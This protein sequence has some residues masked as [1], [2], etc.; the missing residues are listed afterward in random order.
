MA[1]YP[2]CRISLAKVMTQSKDHA[3][4]PDQ[5]SR[6]PRGGPARL[7]LAS[8]APH[9]R[10]K[11]SRAE[12]HAARR[13]WFALPPR[14]DGPGRARRAR[15]GT[16]ALDDPRDRGAGGAEPAAAQPAP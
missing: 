4:L 6:G 9:A 12:R 13:A 16:A 15:K 14:A 11:R 3:N 1:E 2:L 5:K 8:V 10:G 7:D